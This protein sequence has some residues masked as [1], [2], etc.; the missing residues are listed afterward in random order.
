MGFFGSLGR[1]AFTLTRAP[2]LAPNSTQLVRV[3]I[4]D[5]GTWQVWGSK[6]PWW[7]QYES[8]IGTPQR[9]TLTDA[10][11]RHSS[12]GVGD[13]TVVN[14]PGGGIGMGPGSSGGGSTTPGG[15][16]STPDGAGTTPTEPM[17]PLGPDPGGNLS[18]GSGTPPAEPGVTPPSSGPTVPVKPAP[19]KKKKGFG[20]KK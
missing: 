11:W 10:S 4:G 16:S 3:A 7:L 1:Q 9:M 13:G 5:T 2:G 12:G 6:D 8:P 18:P 15:G 17:V 20:T 14:P 19:V